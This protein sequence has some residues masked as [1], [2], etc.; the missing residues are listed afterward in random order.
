MRKKVWDIISKHID[1]GISAE[2]TIK[3]IYRSYGKNSAVST[4]IRKIK[5]DN[6]SGGNP[7]LKL[8]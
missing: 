6:K 4:I 8:L 7:N 2:E 5:E 3:K 1:A